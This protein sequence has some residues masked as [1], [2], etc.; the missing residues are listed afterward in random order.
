[1]SAED[2]YIG[3]ATQL[4]T[5]TGVRNIIEGWPTDVHTTEAFVVEFLGGNRVG[6]TNVM[7]WRWL[8]HALVRKQVNN[9]SEGATYRMVDTVMAAFSPRLTDTAGHNRAKLGG[10]AQTCWFEDVRTGEGDGEA[11][12]GGGDSPTIFRRIG[13]TLV[14]KTHEEF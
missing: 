14:V 2:V 4:R 12:F 11:A 13:F 6:A 3:I 10:H 1:M 5:Y 9:L 8:L 7:H